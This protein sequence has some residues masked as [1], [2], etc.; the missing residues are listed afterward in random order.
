MLAVVAAVAV[1]IKPQRDFQY[2]LHQV[3]IPLLLV[4]VG[5]EEEDHLLVVLLLLE[6]M[7]LHQYFL[8]SHL[9]V[10]VEEVLLQ[11]PEIRVVLVV[12]LVVLHIMAV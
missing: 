12:V 5:M 1:V 9:P 10:E 3:L 7:E 11:V 2:Q 8:V 6:L 4:L